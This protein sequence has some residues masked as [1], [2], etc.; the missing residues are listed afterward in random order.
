MAYWELL[1]VHLCPWPS[2]EEVV[3]LFVDYLH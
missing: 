3:C 1:M 2:G